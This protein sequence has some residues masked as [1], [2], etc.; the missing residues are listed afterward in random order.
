[1]AVTA[2][3][4][5]AAAGEHRDGH[6]SSQACAA[7]RPEA[8][9]RLA[10]PGRRLRA[11]AP[12]PGVPGPAYPVPPAAARSSPA[13]RDSE[14][15][16]SAGLRP[17]RVRSNSRKPPHEPGPSG[18]PAPP[19]AGPCPARRAAWRREGRSAGPGPWRGWRRRST[20]AA[21]VAVGAPRNHEPLHEV[22]RS[23]HTARHGGTPGDGHYPRRR[24]VRPQLQDDLP[25]GD[26]KR[27]AP[28]RDQMRRPM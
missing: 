12:G 3:L 22:K 18:C 25:P 14:S 9:S 24:R 21:R 26:V 23:G 8:R 19:A 11:S 5:V 6:R 15:Q 10:A 27:S 20:Q 16:P 17:P 28:G 7:G 4:R 1:M 13:G 2:A